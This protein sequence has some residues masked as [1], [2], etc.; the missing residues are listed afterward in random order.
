MK[1]V[2]A[3]TVNYNTA[4]DTIT[5]LHSLNKAKTPDI[6][7]DTIIV[8]NGSEDIFK[9]PDTV[10]K[11]NIKLIRSETNTGFSG[12]YNIGMKEAL[13]SDAGYILIINNDTIVDPDMIANLLSVLESKPEI[14]VTT[15]KIYFA[16]GHEFHKDRYKKSDLGKVLWYAGGHTDWNNV[17]SIH[18]GID[19]V[20]HGQ[21]DTIE[22]TDFASGCCMMFKREVLEKA[23]LLDDRYF[24]YYEDADLNERIKRKGFKMYYVP[25]AVLIHVNAAS[26]GGAGNILHDY[27]LTRNKMLFGMTYAPVRTKLALIRESLRLLK[28]GRPFQKLGIRDYYLRKFNKGTFFE[29]RDN[30]SFTM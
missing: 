11:K 30:L 2:A 29:M 3:V 10:D 8:D 23:G 6:I 26:T 13:S 17:I 7:L 15:P 14:G 21:Y 18:R 19:E 20:D 16:K 25:G 12:G 9:L 4:K 22:E 28:S 27:F 5:F 24:L 1:K